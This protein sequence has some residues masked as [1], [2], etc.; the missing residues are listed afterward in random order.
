MSSGCLNSTKVKAEALRLGF[1]SC[2]LSPTESVEESHARFFRKWLSLGYHAEMQ[3]M[4]NH[5]EM[6]LHPELLVPGVRT[7]ISVAFCYRPENPVPFL[8]MYAQG[9]DYHTILRIRLTQ[10]MQAI[11]AT[12]RCFVDTAPVLER[13]WAWRSGIGWIGKNAQLY[14]PGVGSTVFLG[15]LFVMEEA[16]TYDSPI[17]SS[18]NNCMLCRHDCPHGALTEEG[19]DARRCLSYLTIEHRGSLP[20]GLQL[21]DGFYGCDRCLVACPHPHQYTQE[22][23][24]LPSQELREMSMEDWQQLTPERYT[25]LFRKSAVKRAKYEGLLRNIR[26]LNK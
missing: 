7:I 22:P 19:V 17:P 8:S 13:Y 25:Q 4:V 18:C 6:R 5:Q 2:G 23:A 9:E 21:Q 26:A 15:E 1:S 14:V 16:D 12:G 10:L 3:Y 24:F 11:G 20:P